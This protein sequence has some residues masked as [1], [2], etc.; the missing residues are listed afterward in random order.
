M[1][2]EDKNKPNFFIKKIKQQEDRK[3]KFQRQIKQSVWSGLGMSG[4]IGWT[5]SVSTLT[6]VFFGMWLDTNYKQTFSWTLTFLITGLLTGTG[7]AWHWVVRESKDVAE[8]E[9]PKDE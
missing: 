2:P 1:E 5:I 4:L 9:D 8:E 7:M 6:G 3:L